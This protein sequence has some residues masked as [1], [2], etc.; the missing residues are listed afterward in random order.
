M[1]QQ[2]RSI[3]TAGNLVAT[4]EGS[5][6]PSGSPWA[7][8]GDPAERLRSIC[9]T[10]PQADGSLAECC[11][12]S[13]HGRAPVRQPSLPRRPAPLSLE[14][15]SKFSSLGS[16]SKCLAKGGEA[17]S[18]RA[19]A[20]P[21]SPPVNEWPNTQTATTYN[22]EPAVGSAVRRPLRRTISRRVGRHF[23]GA[24]FVI[25]DRRRVAGAP[26]SH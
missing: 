8:A 22:A 23:V 5:E 9:G 14:I 18:H 21:F 2:F 24:R 17:V 26:G 3:A 15:R 11:R 6:P 10:C 4:S 19:G 7:R 13:F 20:V 12:C 1:Y 16:S 25:C